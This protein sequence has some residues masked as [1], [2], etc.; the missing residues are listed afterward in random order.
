MTR[1]ICLGLILANVGYFAWHA[2]IV[3]SPGGAITSMQSS[4]ML[5]LAREAPATV[6]APAMQQSPSL[7]GS[8]AS[9]GP[10][11]DLTETV[12]T[13]AALRR[14]GMSPR[15]RAVE[16]A[17]WAGYW[18]ALEGI[19][20]VRDADAAIA[21]LRKAGIADSYIM[22]AGEE[23]GVTV[24]LGLFTERRRAMTR[25][26]E[27]RALG[28]EP[29]LSPRQRSGTVYWID[30]NYEGIIDQLDLTSYEGDTGRIVRLEIR[31]CD[32]PATNGTL[33]GAVPSVRE[34]PP[35]KDEAV[36]DSR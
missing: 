16:G 1:I 30:V 36:V 32:S 20:S 18:V 3:P 4:A 24:S 27:V 7:P 13:A 34:A 6:S 2:W 23:S 5:I 17:V 9:I 21:R 33:N 35:A 11:L 10:F 29:K 31:P 15:H 22:P 26:D 25:V 19:Q 12:K 14:K 28:F 8:C